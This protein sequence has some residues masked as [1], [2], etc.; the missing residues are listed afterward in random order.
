MVDRTA[1][2][3][4]TGREVDIRLGGDGKGEGRLI[5]NG[6]I[7]MVAPE[8]GCTVHRYTITVRPV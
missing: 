2:T 4:D 6:G 3:D 7:H 5:G 8:H 1:L